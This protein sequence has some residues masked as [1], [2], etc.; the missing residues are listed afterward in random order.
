MF[1]GIFLAVIVVAAVLVPY[2]YFYTEAVYI[3]DDD[4]PRRKLIVSALK[5]TIVP[6]ILVVILLAVGLFLHSDHIGDL[7]KAPEDDIDTEKMLENE[8][9]SLFA[10]QWP[11]KLLDYSSDNSTMSSGT[12]VDE[13]ISSLTSEASSYSTEEII[14]DANT[15]IAYG[16]LESLLDSN[17]MFLD[18]ISVAIFMVVN[19]IR[20][21]TDI[22]IFYHHRNWF[23]CFLAYVYGI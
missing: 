20:V 23:C 9:S 11:R 17:S 5:Y 21:F 6:V 16:Y 19:S 3:E 15:A 18:S 4:V 1:A 14:V 2:T 12:T 10:A 13:S 7:I 22:R 8:N